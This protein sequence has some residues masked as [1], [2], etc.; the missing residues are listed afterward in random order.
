MLIQRMLE[1]NRSK[2]LSS[3]RLR[4]QE[5]LEELTLNADGNEETQRCLNSGAEDALLMFY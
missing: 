4:V 2:R 1:S 3:A 5:G